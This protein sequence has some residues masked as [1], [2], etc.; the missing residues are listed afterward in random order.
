M[1]IDETKLEYYR[2][3]GKSEKDVKREGKVGLLPF[4][5]SIRQKWMYHR[6]LVFPEGRVK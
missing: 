1:N 5:Q 6:K 2:N 3:M 4:G